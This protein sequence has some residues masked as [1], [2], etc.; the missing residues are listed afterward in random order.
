MD[1]Q[2]KNIILI[3]F[4]GSGKTTTGI[5]L[6][7]KLQ[8]TLLDTDKMIEKQE[9]RSISE[10]FA[11]E[12]EDYFRE[13]ETMLLEKLKRGTCRQIY[14]VGGGTPLREENR[15]LLG[16]LG[17]VIYLKASP[18]TVYERLKGDVTRP[19]LQRDDPMKRIRTLLA[20][21]ED[22]YRAAADIVVCVDGKKPAQVVEEIVGVL[23]QKGEEA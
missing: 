16:E 22:L 23:E 19:L 15:R 5:S 7:Y 13:K 2:K 3:G 11:A 17:T 9:G 12:G 21:R 6:S 1:G 18:E 8:C 14:S 20:E 4:M 10:I